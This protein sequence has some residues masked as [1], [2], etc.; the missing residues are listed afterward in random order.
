MCHAGRLAPQSFLRLE[1]EDRRFRLAVRLVGLTWLL[2][3]NVYAGWSQAFRKAWMGTVGTGLTIAG[4]AAIWHEILDV[5]SSY[6]RRSNQAAGIEA[7]IPR[8]A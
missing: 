4:V 1:C 6:A 3:Y 2:D 5:L 8:A 7:H